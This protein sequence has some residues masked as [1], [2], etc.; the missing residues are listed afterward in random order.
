[1]AVSFALQLHG[2][3][4]LGKLFAMPVTVSCGVTQFMH[5]DPKYI[6]DIVDDRRD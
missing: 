2:P 1:V 4:N 3:C 6:E 5:Q